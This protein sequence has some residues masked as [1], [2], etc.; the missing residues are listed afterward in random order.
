MLLRQGEALFFGMPPQLSKGLAACGLA[1]PGEFNLADHALFV[2][3]SEAEEKIAQLRASLPTAAPIS[4]SSSS[5]SSSTSLAADEGLASSSSG[6]AMRTGMAVAHKASAGFTVQAVQLAK[7]ELQGLWRNKPGFIA[8]FLV[9]TVLNLFFALIFFKVGL[10]L[11][12]T[13][14]RTL[15]LTLTLTRTRTRTRTQMLIVTVT[16]T[17]T[18]TRS[19]TLTLTLT[20]TKVG[21]TS[22]E[23]YDT[24]SHFGGM[25]QIAI[26][27]MFGSAQ[28]RPRPAPA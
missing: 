28:P 5:S 14:T 4:S 27:G 1:C 25:T 6:H 10:T 8:T 11:T 26:G 3:Q 13:R 21:D 19:L 20:L 17:P 23:S 16:V 18:V 24:M 2:V 12:R 9:P 22:L 15:T 7:R